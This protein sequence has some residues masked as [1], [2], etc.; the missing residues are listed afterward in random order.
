[1]LQWLEHHIYTSFGIIKESYSRIQNVLYGIRQGNS[2]S[3]IV[4]IDNSGFIFKR[5]E[6]KKLGYIVP[7]PISVN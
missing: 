5:I 2:L 4:Y 1:M 6:N 7:M 3:G